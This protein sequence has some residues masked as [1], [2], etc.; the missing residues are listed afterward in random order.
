[1]LLGFCDRFERVRVPP[2]DVE[3]EHLTKE[4]LS[5]MFAADITDQE[6]IILIDVAWRILP[7]A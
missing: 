4:L 7:R 3:R 6:F 1:L 5:F 2:T